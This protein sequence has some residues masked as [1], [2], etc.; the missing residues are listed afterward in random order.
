MV[1]LV[2]LQFNILAGVGFVVEVGL[3]GCVVVGLLIIVLTFASALLLFGSPVVSLNVVFS[4][5]RL[6]LKILSSSL[7]SSFFTLSLALGKLGQLI[8]PP[9]FLN[10]GSVFDG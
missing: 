8:F 4:A 10:V 2:F 3:W 1:W 5:R 9:D 6:F 7:S